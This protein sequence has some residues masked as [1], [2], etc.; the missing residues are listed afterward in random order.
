MSSR[1]RR[2]I[3]SARIDR[4][5]WGTDYEEVDELAAASTVGAPRPPAMSIAP[6]P[7]APA[8]AAHEVTP[9]SAAEHQ[10]RLAALERDAFAKGYAQGERAGIEA[11]AKRTEAMLRRVAQTL[12]DLAQL[13]KTIVRETERQMVQLAIALA[14]RI[15]LRDVSLDPTL[16]AAMA[17]VALD[18]LGE[19]TPATIKLHPDDYAAI[20]AQR[21]EQWGGAQVTVLPDTAVSRGGCL[22][23]SDFGVV[24]GSLDAQFEEMTRALLGDGHGGHEGASRVG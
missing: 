18:R 14:R 2:I 21:G 9:A 15:V 3:E 22:V 20:C 7:P 17:H 1:A 13:R 19:S 10:A 23:E 16:V 6:P 12:E 5:D 8:P 4:F 24:D 11:G